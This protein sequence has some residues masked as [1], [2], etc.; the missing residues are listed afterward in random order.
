MM[1]VAQPAGHIEAFSVDLFKVISSGIHDEAAI[2]AVFL[3]HNMDVVGPPLPK[4][5][6]PMTTP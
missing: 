1:V 6:R 2:K 5:H 4:T 3:K